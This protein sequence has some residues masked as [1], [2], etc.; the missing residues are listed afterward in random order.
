MAQKHTWP[1]QKVTL[2]ITQAQVYLILENDP[3]GQKIH[4]AHFQIKTALLT[5][6]AANPTPS[7]S[8][9]RGQPQRK[10]NTINALP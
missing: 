2:K 7:H 10:V 4:L 5:V 1:R 6:T 3:Y 9:Q 8:N